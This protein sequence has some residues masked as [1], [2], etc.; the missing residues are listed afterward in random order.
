MSELEVT[1]RILKQEHDELKAKNTKLSTEKEKYGK[2]L[3][4]L[5]RKNDKNRAK[6]LTTKEYLVLDNHK[7]Y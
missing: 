1:N 7:F 6:Y 2:Q 4:K 5:E 3:S